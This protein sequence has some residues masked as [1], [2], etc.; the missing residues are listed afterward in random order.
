MKEIMMM[1]MIKI[2]L[3]RNRRD[4]WSSIQV[5]DYYN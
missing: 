4:Q 3:Y 5:D 1:M 2:I